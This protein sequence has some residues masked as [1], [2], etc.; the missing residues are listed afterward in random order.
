VLTTFQ[1]LGGAM[2]VAVV[3]VVFFGLLTGGAAPAAFAVTPALRAQLTEAHLSPGTVNGAV[4]TFTRCFEA[5]ASSSNPQQTAPGCPSVAGTTSN[6]TTSAFSGAASSA[7]AKD[8]VGA[9]EVLLF[10]NIGFWVLT[11]LLSLALPR[12]RPR[13]ASGASAAH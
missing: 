6:P 5:E 12:A 11:A 7:L 2:G 8:F 4:A 1:Q 10:F 13:G 9:V 3:G